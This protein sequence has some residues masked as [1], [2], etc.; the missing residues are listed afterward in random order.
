MANEII[1]VVEMK[2]DT[3]YEEAFPSYTGTEKGKMVY[4]RKGDT[5]AQR[6][7]GLY[8][9]ITTRKSPSKLTKGSFKVVKGKKK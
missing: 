6:E 8:Y 2:R 3:L 7:D 9:K 1:R 5:Y 4:L